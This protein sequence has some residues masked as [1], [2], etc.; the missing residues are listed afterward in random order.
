MLRAGSYFD[1]S[2]I[3]LT[4]LKSGKLLGSLRLCR[5]PLRFCGGHKHTGSCFFLEL[6][7]PV[8]TFLISVLLPL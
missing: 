5:I 3:I 4:F 1:I 7:A 8:S 2:R 6:E